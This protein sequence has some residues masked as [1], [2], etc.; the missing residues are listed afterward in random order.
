[1]YKHD[2]WYV[3]EDGTTVDPNE[4]SHDKDGVLRHKSGVAVAM[5][6]NVPHSTGVAPTEQKRKKDLKPEESD[7]GYKTRQSEAD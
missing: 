5:K 1:M 3:L 6:G 4:V 7:K 2:T